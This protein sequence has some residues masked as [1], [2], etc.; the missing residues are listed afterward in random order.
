[1]VINANRFRPE[2][3]TVQNPL[4]E[5]EWAIRYEVNVLVNNK[6]RTGTPVI[7][8]NQPTY[9]N[10]MG[11]I[12]HDFMLGAL[13]YRFHTNPGWSAPSRH[14]RVPDSSRPRCIDQP[15]RLGR[16]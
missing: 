5:K 8:E 9:H 7:V 12:E 4:A 11:S 16:A 3:K 6:D 2:E 14:R 1:M 10:L 15:V 13:V